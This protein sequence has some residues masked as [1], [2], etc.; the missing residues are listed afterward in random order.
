M[1]PAPIRWWIWAGMATGELVSFL[2]SFAAPFVAMGFTGVWLV[3]FI[4]AASR[5]RRW[6]IYV[7]QQRPPIRAEVINDRPAI[8]SR[9]AILDRKAGQ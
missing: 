9:F 5:Q 6:R 8:G 4:W 2:L 7:Q 3:A 1:N